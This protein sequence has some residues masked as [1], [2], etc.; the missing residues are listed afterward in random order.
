MKGIA[1][2]AERARQEPSTGLRGERVMREPATASA[3]AAGARRSRDVL[4]RIAR[5]VERP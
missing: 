1:R 4:T 2:E 5:N 3:R